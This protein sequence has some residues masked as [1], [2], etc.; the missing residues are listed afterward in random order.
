MHRAEFEQLALEHLD[1]VYR[2]ALQLTRNPERAEDLVQD[3]YLRALRPGPS[4]RFTDRS[5]A[6]ARP[7]VSPVVGTAESA[8]HGS[9]RVQKPSSAAS[10]SIRAWL[11]TITHNAF[12][13]DAKKRMREQENARAAVRESGHEPREADLAPAEDTPRWPTVRDEPIAAEPAAERVESER[14]ALPAELPPAWNLGAED[15]DRV[16]Q[17]LKAAVRAIRPEYRQVLLLWSLGGMKYR[18]IADL[19]NVPIGTVM[20][21]LHRARKLLA[22]ALGGPDGPAMELGIRPSQLERAR[23]EREEEL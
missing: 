10:E 13:T 12:F 20:S 16:D 11:F 21:R 5:A 14:D 8:G 1:A 15:W 18:E 9:A 3:V 22:D 7:V 2:M 17:R 19:L 4:D 6:A 23:L